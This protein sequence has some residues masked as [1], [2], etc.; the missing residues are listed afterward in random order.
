MIGIQIFDI[1]Y[2]GL[3]KDIIYFIIIYRIW[4]NIDGKIP[5]V[6]L[7]NNR[8]KNWQDKKEISYSLAEVGVFY[9]VG[10]IYLLSAIAA[11]VQIVL[12]TKYSSVLKVFLPRR[13]IFSIFALENTGK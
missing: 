12:L 1:E 8:I 3:M 10:I 5:N 11:L 7:S 4:L 6:N 2:G 9:F 13:L